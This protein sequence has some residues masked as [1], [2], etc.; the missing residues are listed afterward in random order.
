MDSCERQRR[1]D[2][3]FSLIKQ[4]LLP[5]RSEMSLEG[6]QRLILQNSGAD[7]SHLATGRQPS[8]SPLRKSCPSSEHNLMGASTRRCPG[9]QQVW[10]YSSVTV[11]RGVCLTHQR[12]HKHEREGTPSLNT[13][14]RRRLR[15]ARPPAHPGHAFRGCGSI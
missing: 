12:R 9:G 3:T 1:S 4:S 2:I 13:E 15:S 7:K 8:L 10:R 11:W 5:K 14:V 6:T